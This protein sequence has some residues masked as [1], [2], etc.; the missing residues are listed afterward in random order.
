MRVVTGNVNCSDTVGRQSNIKW[1]WQCCQISRT[2]SVCNF[3]LQTM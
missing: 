1:W 3:G 2:A